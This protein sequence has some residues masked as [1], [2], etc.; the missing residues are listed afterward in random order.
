MDIKKAL[1]E[2]RSNS[3]AGPDGVPAI[4]LLKC[5]DAL[6][7][8]LCKL[9][10]HS[11]ASG[12][13]PK[14]VKK[15]LITPTC[16][17]GDEVFHKTITLLHSP[18]TLSES[19]KSASE[20]ELWMERY[21]L[22]TTNQHGFGKRSCLSKL[23]EHHKWVLQKLAIGNNVD[24]MFLD[25]AKAFDTVGPGVQLHKIKVAGVKWKLGKWLHS[26]L[27]GRVQSVIVEHRESVEALITSGVP[28]SLVLGPLLS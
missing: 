5:C 22:F 11:L 25:F 13:V 27:T 20:I 6:A 14:E 10:Q 18:H 7:E 12:Q 21:D 28:Q 26:F 9:W 15:A 24:I 23:W 17:G 8:P 2:L 4:F 1:K 19:L 16:K 3:A